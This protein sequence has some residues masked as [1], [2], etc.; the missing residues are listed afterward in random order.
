[1]VVLDVRM[2]HDAEGI[3]AAREIRAWTPPTPVV[4][5]SQHIESRRALNRRR[6]TSG[7]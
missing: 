1:M 2:P 3:E 6:S 7:R 5:L 4:L